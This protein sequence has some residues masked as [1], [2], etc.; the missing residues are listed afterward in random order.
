LWLRRAVAFVGLV[1]LALN[2]LEFPRHVNNVWHDTSS[3]ASYEYYAARHFQ[4]GQQVFQNI[5]P[6]GYVHY[7]YLYA[8]YLPVQKIVLKTFSR[9]GLFLLVLWVARRLPGSA[10]KFCW[11]AVFF[12]FQPFSPL[13]DWSSLISYPEIDWDQDY[14]YLG[15]YLAALYLLQDRRDWQFRAAAGACLVFLAFTALTKHTAFVLALAAVGAVFLH[16]LQGGFR[17]VREVRSRRREEAEPDV[18]QKSASLR[19]RLAVLES[20]PALG[21]LLLF[22]LALGLFWVLAGQQ[23]ANLPGFV[24]GIFA[25]SSGYSEATLPAPSLQ[26]ALFGLLIAGL[27]L[28]RSLYNWRALKQGLARMMFEGFLLFIA[29]KHGFVQMGFP[30]SGLFFVAALLCAIPFCLLP[31][32]PATPSP[33]GFS[34]RVR[35]IARLLWPVLLAVILLSLIGTAIS[36]PGFGYD[37]GFLFYR[38]K[39]NAAWL[40]SP[41]AKLAEMD[42]DLH[43]VEKMFSLPDIKA[44]V[45]GARMDFFGDVPGWPLLNRLN[46]WSRPMPITFAAWNDALEQ[47]NE[48]FYRNPQ[49]A[50]EFVICDL[51]RTNNRFVA[52]DDA[53]ALRALLDNYHPVLTE[54]QFLLVQ[55]NHLPWREHLEKKPISE[56]RTQ[57]FNPVPLNELSARMIWMEAQL[58]YSCLGQLRAWVY[59]PTPCYISFRLAGEPTEYW[60]RFMAGIGGAGCMLTPLLA[61]NRDLLKF[62]R[63]GDGL[64][65]FRR[66]EVFGFSCDPGDEKYFK[67]E[68]Q[69]R[70]YSVTR[71]TERPQ[72]PEARP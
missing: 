50:P 59:R 48:A 20:A 61:D 66:V 23:L 18:P 56:F 2:F 38:L 9:L 47:A 40:L 4:F 12:I 54:K 62:Y 19:R 72:L 63:P 26:P 67:K 25:F 3:F 6:Y 58:H 30:H 35:Q 14:D 22:C 64:N 42:R 33:S 49:T 29:W 39:N 10:S 27:L 45:Q 24:R 31:A 65:D 44:R 55:K 34:Q 15:I 41:R 53:L 69:V 17:K 32:A 43:A 16:K 51:H 5:G 37:P 11:W 8:G 21:H 52:Q 70:F 7:A 13:F 71:P 68:I 36:S 46:Y 1:L 28:L 57:F 60:N